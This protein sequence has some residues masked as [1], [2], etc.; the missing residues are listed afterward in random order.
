MAKSLGIN[1]RTRKPEL[2]ADPVHQQK[3]RQYRDRT[4]KLYKKIDTWRKAIARIDRSEERL[5]EI[6][7]LLEGFIGYRVWRSVKRKDVRQ[8]RLTMLGR[9]LFCKYALENG[10]RSSEISKYMSSIWKPY[11]ARIRV[12]FQRSFP[13]NPRNRNTWRQFS[14]YMKEATEQQPLKRKYA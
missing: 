2:L 9:Q 4:R 6:D 3:L 11:A 5:R 14:E 7:I 10:L 8:N 1:P 13:T 12:E